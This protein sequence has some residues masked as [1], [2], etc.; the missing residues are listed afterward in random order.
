MLSYQHSYHAGNFADVIK[1]L[2]LTNILVYLSRKDK[3]FFYY[4][5]HAG[6][7]IYDLASDAAQKTRES[8]LGVG[9][10]WKNISILPEVFNDYVALIKSYNSETELRYYPGSPALAIKLTRAIDRLYFNELHP[11]EY[12]HLNNLPKFGRRVFY[13][14][15]DGLI[16]LPRLLPPQERR[17]LIFFDP[18]YELKTEYSAVVQTLSIAQK[19]FAN[20]VFAL[21]YPVINGP[22][23]AR[24]IANL[25]NINKNYLQVE[26]YISDPKPQGMYGCGVWIINPPYIL[27]SGLTEAFEVLQGIYNSDNCLYFD[28]VN[29]KLIT[30]C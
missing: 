13:N 8:D 22:W 9:L 16:Q 10:L 26:F 19:K 15:G 29:Y 14:Q 12:M 20:G 18:A 6:R 1:H 28:K 4:E 30:G 5:S 21:W 2:I 23:H 3:P 27:E 24:L 25:R 11:Q 17:G 7:G